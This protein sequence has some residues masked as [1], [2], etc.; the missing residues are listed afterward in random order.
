MENCTIYSHNL[1]FEKV[2]QIVKSN[3]PKAKIEYNDGGMQKSLVAEIKGGFFG[4]SK[5]LKINYRERKNPSYKLE[6]VEC[7]LTQNLAGMV[8]FIQSLP[9]KN[10]EVR[11]KFLY[12]V[13]SANCEIPFIAEPEI[14]P[15]FESVL[16]R[17]AIELDG[18][19]FAQPN[20][21]F[22]KSNGQ[23]FVDKN[24]NLI[25]DMNGNCEVQDV[26]IN[27]NSKYHDQPK[28][29]YTEEQIKRKEKSEAFLA[30]NGIKTNN[31]LP[32]ISS[33][34]SVELR[35]LK[36]IIDRAYSLLIIAVKGEG[37]E[38]EHLAKTIQVKKIESFSPKENQ[39]YQAESLNDQE[40]AYATWRY[41]SLYAMLW[42]L[43]KMD[44]LKY[45]SEICDVQG[46][47]G[48]IFQPSREEFE[49]SVKLRS[50]S[51]ILDE[52]DKTYRMNWACVDAR[53]KG[54]Q[55][56]GNINPSVVH[57][58]HYSLNWLTNYQNQDWDDVQTNT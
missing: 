42:A 52:L 46:I 13:M 47:V 44:E 49:N 35:T 7:G 34:E 9:A 6:Q 3:L 17:I 41:E 29:P 51:E 30:E 26:E 28:E 10:E 1:E 48:K 23:H 15:E 57:E 14:S 56:S 31:N 58:R 12:K 40:R 39:I 33:S 11:N 4:K 8:N 25:L 54:Q 36:E 43:G 2:V 50:K 45:P 16:R 37:I 20:R 22:N 32:C 38:Q 27:V 18:F 53:I 5:I 55:V 21:I 19:V 24:L